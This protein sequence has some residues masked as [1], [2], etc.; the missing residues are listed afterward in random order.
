MVLS[1]NHFPSAIAERC[2]VVSL[3]NLVEGSIFCLGTSTESAANIAHASFTGV[4]MVGL[5]KA[6]VGRTKG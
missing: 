4:I 2:A 5:D 6:G 3:I 1:S